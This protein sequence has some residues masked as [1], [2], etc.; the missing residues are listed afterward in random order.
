MS[1][2]SRYTGAGV[3]GLGGLALGGALDLPWWATGLLGGLGGF[4]G[5][6]I[7]HGF[8]KIKV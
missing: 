5:H 2:F 7:Q 1:R 3:G 8:P 4:A 6:A